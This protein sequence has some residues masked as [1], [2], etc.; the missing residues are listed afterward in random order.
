MGKFNEFRKRIAGKI[1]TFYCN[2]MYNKAMLKA[3]ERHAKD[4]EMIYVVDHF[5]KGQLLSAINRK[6][7]RFIK[8]T[9]Q[10]MHRDELYWSPA[11]GVN[12]LKEQC[13]YHTA[14]RSGNQALTEKDKEIRR[15]AFIRAGLKK[16]RLYK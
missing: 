9:A 6:E 4:G 16:A 5:I 12:M 15:L 11:Y 7:F 8:H 2:R 3:E 13:W 10:K 1:V 14:D